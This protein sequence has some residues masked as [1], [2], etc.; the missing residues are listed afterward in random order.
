VILFV[1]I[2]GRQQW[3][4]WAFPAG[5]YNE[6]PESPDFSYYDSYG[7][8]DLKADRLALVDGSKFANLYLSV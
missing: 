1:N 3:C 7:G 5:Q 4:E 8:F 2:T 6:I